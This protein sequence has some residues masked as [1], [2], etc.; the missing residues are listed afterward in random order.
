MCLD[1]T[2]EI[3]HSINVTIK[4]TIKRNETNI[5][6]S[7]SMLRKYDVDVYKN[8]NNAMVICFPSSSYISLKIGCWDVML[9]VR[10]SKVKFFEDITS[11]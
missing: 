8:G 6:F 4:L 1:V 9:S 11:L 3:G 10:G 7:L 2:A 5:L